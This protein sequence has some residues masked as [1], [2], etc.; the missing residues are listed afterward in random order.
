MMRIFICL[1]LEMSES[2]W[3]MICTCTL[4]C[5]LDTCVTACHFYPPGQR[6]M[7]I[8]RDIRD[9]ETVPRV[10]EYM[11]LT[12]TCIYMYNVHTCT[13]TYIIH[14]YMHIVYHIPAIVHVHA[15]VVCSFAS[16]LGS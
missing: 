3:T 1:T 8:L 14:V 4:S 12:S 9:T 15:F 5:T 16:P 10:Y 6:L 13:C 7:I 2:M 11:Y